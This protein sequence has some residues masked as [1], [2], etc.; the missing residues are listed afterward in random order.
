[1]LASRWDGESITLC[2]D[3]NYRYLTHSE[4][5]STSM[6]PPSHRQHWNAPTLQDRVALG[7]DGTIAYDI[8]EAKFDPPSIS[9]QRI[10]WFELPYG[11]VENNTT[12]QPRPLHHTARNTATQASVEINRV[13]SR[14]HPRHRHI[15]IVLGTGWFNPAHRPEGRR[16]EPH[17]E[18][19]APGSSRPPSRRSCQP[20][21]RG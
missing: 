5:R 9:S 13:L 17:R 21:Q 3:L 18:R 8:K 20:L 11:G 2:N 6:I 14:G 1:M 12:H 16:A 10:M 19:R 15:I 7:G 4:A